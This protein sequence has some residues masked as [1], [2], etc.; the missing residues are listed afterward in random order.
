MTGMVPEE[1]ERMAALEETMWWYHGLHSNVRHALLKHAPSLGELLDAG[2]GTGGTL[3]MI[4]EA[5]PQA[6]LH[7]IDLSAQACAHT[8]SK[9]GASVEVGSVEDLPYPQDSFDALVSCDVLG[10]P[11][12]VDRTLAGFHRVLRPGGTCVIN[13][14]A[15]GWMLSYHD[16]AVGQVHRFSRAEGV[17]LM[18]KHG[19][20]PLSASY[21]NTVLF[22]LMVIRRKLLPA[23]AAS[24]VT[25]V[26]P[27]VNTLFKG[28]LATES[29][30]MD[31]DVRLPFGG[32][33]L[34]IAQKART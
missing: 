6:R 25:P 20:Q 19:L 31:R 33:V 22:P 29:A 1:Y 27:L 32:S 34:I 21:W 4:G 13:L 18:R 2:C 16:K 17:A 7:G 12:D 24:D 11:I 14:A 9:T 3:K 5:F 15:Y 8:R 23:P 30:L 26:A 10:Y 28:C